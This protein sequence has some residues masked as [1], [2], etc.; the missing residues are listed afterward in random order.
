MLGRSSVTRGPSDG[1]ERSLPLRT[2]ESV[3][4]A[5]DALAALSA[6]ERGVVKVLVIVGDS[7]PVSMVARAVGHLGIRPAGRTVRDADVRRAHKQLQQSGWTSP[8]KELRLALPPHSCELLTRAIWLSETYTGV[9]DAVSQ[10]YRYHE[11]SY[12]RYGGVARSTRCKARV[13]LYTGDARALEAFVQ[14]GIEQAE[15]LSWILDPVEPRLAEKLTPDMCGWLARALL[16]RALDDAAEPDATTAQRFTDA[17]ALLRDRGQGVFDLAEVEFTWAFLCGDH[18]RCRRLVESVDQGD[19]HAP[20][21]M[22]ELASGAKKASVKSFIAAFEHLR[23]L[24]YGREPFPAPIELFAVLALVNSNATHR[25]LANTR[26]NYMSGSS[27]HYRSPA[28]LAAARHLRSILDPNLS[29]PKGTSPHPLTALISGL[30][31]YWADQPLDVPGLAAAEANARTLGWHWVADELAALTPGS[32]TDRATSLRHLREVSARWKAQLAL[33]RETISAGGDGSRQAKERAKR[34]VWRVDLGRSHGVEPVLQ[35]RTKRGWTS[36]RAVSLKRLYRDVHSVEGLDEDDLK[37]V[38]HI[39][40]TR[41]ASRYHRTDYEFDESVW[42]ALVGHPRVQKHDGTPVTVAARQPKIAITT[43]PTSA[44]LAVDDA[45]YDE[46]LLTLIG[47]TGVEVLHFNLAQRRI[48]DAIPDGLTVPLKERAE[49]DALLVE[50]QDRF[51]TGQEGPE[52]VTGSTH[53]VLQLTPSRLETLRAR[54][55][56]RPGGPGSLAIRPGEGSAQVLTVVD[57]RSVRVTRDLVQEHS[58]ATAVREALPTLASA[59]WNGEHYTLTDL[60]SSLNLLEEIH[61]LTASRPEALTVEWPEGRA[62]KLRVSSTDALS[63]SVKTRQ[64]WFE[65]SGQL[66]V[67]EELTLTLAELLKATSKQVG[68]YVRLDDGSF[69]ALAS[70]I[71]DQL[72][73]L[74]RVSTAKAK[75]VTVHRLASKSLEGLLANAGKTRSDKGWKQHLA[76]VTTA[77][78]VAPPVPKTLKATLRPYQ[79]DA[80]AWL[81]RLAALGVGACLADD[82]GLGKT[83]VSLALLLQRRARGP[84]LVVA[85]TSVEGGWLSEAARFAPSLRVVALR[86]QD[87]TR[88]LETLG[89]HDVLVCS[90]GL[91][92]SEADA[93]AAVDWATV[94]CDEGQAIKNPA[95]QRHKAACSLAAEMRV[96]LTGTPIQNHLGEIHA[97]FSFL[98]PGMF[99][100]AGK[101]RKRFVKPIEGGDTRARRQLA[102]LLAPTVLRRTKTEVLQDLPPRTEVDVRV[103]PN[104]QEAALHEALRLEAVRVL[105]ADGQTETSQVAVLAQLTR[106]RLA[107]CNPALALPEGAPPIPSSKLEAFSE[108]IN[109]LRDGGHRALVFSQFVKH[110]ALL[111]GALEAAG[112]DFLYLDG[113]TPVTARQQRVEAFQRGEGD[114]FLISLK[115]GGVGLNLTGADYVIHVDPWWNPAIEDQASDRAHRIGQTRPVTVYRLI[116]ADTIEEKILALH[117]DKRD[118]A[119]QVLGGTDAATSMSTD[120]L[121]GLLRDGLG[122]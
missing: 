30:A 8:G 112:V 82:M 39:R 113:A 98:N 71:R 122:G 62:L 47:D 19:A 14:A 9:L 53:P 5:R 115:A 28:M 63:V 27:R 49:L 78:P 41:W 44:T 67:D 54:L 55:V 89:A 69:L 114:V 17:L 66:K 84:A 16:S 107:A 65:A 43:S 33:F 6:V 116:A 77:K 109:Q 34:I 10:A 80:Y 56:V 101:F 13:S 93:L 104:P 91:L 51:E 3:A 50:L 40:E 97:L 103:A 36:G 61:Q 105:T 45:G 21:A 24:G 37:V 31:V 111:R 32:E 100:S 85:P 12:S 68:R 81:N 42:G 59:A 106:L 79:E 64:E 35:S 87:R 108:L 23:E 102:Q 46:S 120:E 72:D 48:A 2:F 57:K 96:I 88:L 110:L 22:L 15:P 83:V 11:W 52:A 90:Y 118:I 73:A 99:G 74:E 92:V 1:S 20:R 29:V 26:L 70:G 7:T 25:K 117:R 4:S 58:A 76:S 121:I 95:T 60:H 94:I 38:S 119:D 18:Q 75:K 86:G